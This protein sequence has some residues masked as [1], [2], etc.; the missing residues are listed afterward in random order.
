LLRKGLFLRIER[1]MLAQKLQSVVGL[2]HENKKIYGCKLAENKKRRKNK[3]QQLLY[4]FPPHIA[5]NL[6]ICRII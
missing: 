1:R 3:G 6:Y 4:V 2:E 5:S